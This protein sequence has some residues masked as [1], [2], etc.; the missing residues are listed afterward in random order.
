MEAEL[1]RYRPEVEQSQFIEV[2]DSFMVRNPENWRMH[3]YG[4]SAKIR[5]ARKYSFSDRC[6]YYVPVPEV[7]DSINRLI[8]NLSSVDIPLTLINQ[9]MPIQYNKIR[10][11]LLKKDPENLLKDRIINCINDYMYATKL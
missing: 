2:L 6:R 3:Y 8:M 11:G 10:S 1:F 7:K 4:D 9:F 5:Y